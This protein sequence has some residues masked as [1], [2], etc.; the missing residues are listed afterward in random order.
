[1]EIKELSP[2]LKIQKIETEALTHLLTLIISEN[3]NPRKLIKELGGLDHDGK[4]KKP[5]KFVEYG[6]NLNSDKKYK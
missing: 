6:V 4:A 5:E 1:M 2:N 3:L